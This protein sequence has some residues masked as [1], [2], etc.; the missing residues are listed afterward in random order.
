MANSKRKSAARKQPVRAG[1]GAERQR[2]CFVVSGFGRKT[3]YS[4]GRVLNLDKTYEQLIHPAC[5][6]V[7]VNC[8]RAID[9]N[10]TGSI[11]AII[12][13]WIYEADIVI[14]DL[15]T[16]NAYVFYELGVRHAQRPNTTIIIA[17]SVL[18]QKIPFDLSSFVIHQYEHGG[19]EI[20]HKEQD[21]FV[22]HLA[23]VL[24]KILAAEQRRREAAPQARRE[25][26]SPVFK[27]LIGMTPPA[28]DAESYIEPPAYIP[29][30]QREKKEAQEGESLASVIDAAEA[31]WKS[32]DFPD[33]IRLF[34]RAIVMQ[35]EGMPDKKPDVSLAQRLA[36]VTYKGGEKRDADGNLDKEAAIAALHD[37]EDILVKY[38]APKISNDAETLGLSGAINKRLFQ[39]SGDLE[40][41]DRAIRFYE[42]GFYVKQDYYSGINVAS[43]YTQR[44]NLLPDRFDAIVS[45]GH[46]NMIR[47]QV[48]EICN[49]LIE[50][51]ESFA[52][53]GDRQWVYMTLGEAYQG[54]GR[55][56]DEERVGRKI[57]RE[58]TEF[59]K[60]SYL[61]QKE[62]LEAAMAEF[63]RRV[64]PEQLDF[65]PGTQAA[66]IPV[67]Q[68]AAMPSGFA[69]ELLRQIG[70][71][72]SGAASSASPAATGP[73]D[74]PARADPP[75]V[76]DAADETTIAE[77][78]SATPVPR[79]ART[80][81]FIS[82]SHK[83]S[84]WLEEVKKHLQVLQNVG[85][86]IDVWDDSKIPAGNLWKDEIDKAL[87]EAKVALLLITTNY[88]ASRFIAKDELPPLLQ[89]AKQD[90][91]VILSLLC[92]PVYWEV[93]PLAQFQAVNNP[94]TEVLDELP[95]PK[96]Q[97]VLIRLTKELAKIFKIGPD[98]VVSPSE[99]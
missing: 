41:L 5:D 28:Y 72:L 79:R 47:Q 82:Y 87:S 57:E 56:A 86:V 92:A 21:R 33:A 4:T 89:A 76:A 60:D 70:R 24:A 54:L 55:T 84:E 25:S 81:V 10:L 98:Q 35:T 8:F 80:K 48:A 12:Y 96:Q 52:S 23:D 20:S 91:A 13:R 74:P 95:P 78:G 36:L 7:N 59:G 22:N 77:S 75:P 63:E 44:A 34:G 27:F 31:A 26:D 39:L 15:S 17:E 83:D 29:P 32:R 61:W 94:E 37:A 73:I 93:S 53:R 40:Y 1:K 6:K 11:D 71:R 85:L 46:A 58:A 45:Y 66:A 99:P 65:S 19:E 88:L 2:T 69:D 9:A 90:G 14:A 50:D 51:E 62:K 64:S 49:E 38:C 42:R 97:R 3:D 43:M 68:A 18:M 30:E 67:A 16:L